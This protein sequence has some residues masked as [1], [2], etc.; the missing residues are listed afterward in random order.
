MPSS[1]RY[2]YHAVF[3]PRFRSNKAMKRY[4]SGVPRGSRV[5]E[6]GSGR[7]IRNSYP[8]SAT[9]YFSHCEFIR[10]DV[11]P[12]FGHEV[13]DITTP[14]FEEEFD[15]VL[16]SSVLEHIFDFEAAIQGINR[17]LRKGGEAR[18]RV[19]FL[20]PLHDEPGDY[21]RFTEHALRVML[22]GFQ[23]IEIRAEGLRR[24]PFGYVALVR[25]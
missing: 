21:W 17:V 16:A 19:P 22:A 15:F 8:Y 2:L 1:F 13:V 23:S 10:S 3:W 14:Q 5:L 4:A 7:R 11:D 12:N 18:I 24:A 25:K 9:R 6:I 20:Y